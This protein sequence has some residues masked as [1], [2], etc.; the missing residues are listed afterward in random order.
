MY[1]ELALV[2]GK[3]MATG[4]FA[5]S[6]IDLGT[7]QEDGDDTENVADNGEEGVVD[8]GDKGKNKVES[9]TIRSTVSKSRKRGYAVMIVF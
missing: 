7:Q 6:Y 5:K 1:D 8:K 4:S 3:D 9:S 2:V